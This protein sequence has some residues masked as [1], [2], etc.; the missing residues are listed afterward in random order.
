MYVY[1]LY[2]YVCVYVCMCVCVYVCLCVCACRM[3]MSLNSMFLYD[4]LKQTYK[5]SVTTCHHNNELNNY[6]TTNNSFE[7][8][9]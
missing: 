3:N 5:Q 6:N 1:T 2:M 7:T 4:D 9:L 8:F